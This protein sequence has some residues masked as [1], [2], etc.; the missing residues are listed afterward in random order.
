MARKIITLGL[1]VVLLISS[2]LL[3]AGCTDQPPPQ[4]GQPVAYA[5]DSNATSE[6]VAQVVNGSNQ[7]A[8]DFYKQIENGD[9]NIF[10]S[11]YSISVAMAMIYEG[12][13]GNTSDEMRAVLHFLEDD[14]VRR[15][16]F[17]WLYNNLNKN[18]DY[19]LSTTNALWAQEGYKFLDEYFDLMGKY[20]MGKITNLDFISETEESRVTINTW[21]EENTN[22][23][24]KDM[25]PKGSIHDLTRLV[26]TNAIYFKGTWLKQFD[27]SDTKDRDFK[28]DQD[29]TIKVPM[30][31]I[32]EER[33]NYASAPGF[34]IL[35]MPYKGEKLSMLIL[36][37]Y[38]GNM[39][40]LEDSLT[41]ENLSYWR[42]N[43]YQRSMDIF[44]PKFK[45]ETKYD[46]KETLIDMGMITAFT[47]LVPDFSGIDGTNDLYLDFVFH[48][49]F[50]EVNEKGTEASAAT[51][52]GTAAT[53]I[54]PTFNADH[55]FI[56]LI[57]EM[58]TGNILFM[59]RVS[60]PSK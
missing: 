51:S 11:P 29:N 7:F 18:K 5:D 47:P 30:M 44:I 57:Q 54:P 16:A 35:E 37:P 25:I 19:L 6:G 41:L 15:S 60:D 52:G 27:K 33:F 20:Y 14:D 1:I 48:Q 9:E 24:I 45:F 26:L 4:K 12:A 2:N 50:V 38:E 42:N 43:L 13:R 40:Y 17:A 34:Q 39:D 49:G 36:L 56:F 21:V 53:G 58:E 22:G 31:S 3:L 23:K 32:K 59:G 8:F 55:P 10:F 46:M 28:V